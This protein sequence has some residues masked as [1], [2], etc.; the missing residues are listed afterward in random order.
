MIN[1]NK[2]EIIKN[3]DISLKK[4]IAKKL[5]NNYLS[6]NE[7]NEKI[8]DKALSLDDTLPDIYFEKLKLK[9]NDNNLIQKSYD[10]LDKK[11]LDD[12][13]IEKK[14]NYRDIYFYIINYLEN[15]KLNEPKNAKL[16]F[17]KEGFNESFNSSNSN[18]ES[19]NSKI[20][21]NEENKIL[22]REI[23]IISKVEIKD[24]NLSDS[25]SKLIVDD[26]NKLDIKTLLVQKEIICVKDIKQKFEQI[27]KSLFSFLNYR[28]NYPDF[29][30]EL[31]F[32]NN[33]RYMLEAFQRLI[34]KKFIEKIS[35]IKLIKTFTRKMQNGKISDKF[36]KIYFYYIMNSQYTLNNDIITSLCEYDEND[37]NLLNNNNEFKIENNILYDKH[38]KILI[39]NIDY[40]LI[41]KLI[42]QN[43]LT[44][45]DDLFLIDKP[46]FYSLKGLLNRETTF[47]KEE[48]DKMWEEFLSSSVLNDLLNKL[49]NVEINIFK[50]K[51]LINLF[52]QS[53]Y[54]FPN[55]NDDFVALSHKE[56]MLMYFPP[57]KIF[58]LGINIEK[59]KCILEMIEKSL[60][61]INIQ[62]EWGH[63]SS[64]FLFFNS[65]TKYFNTPDRKIKE[66]RK[67][68]INIKDDIRV[69]EGG[70]TVEYL[71]YGRIINEINTKEAIYILDRNNYQKSLQNFF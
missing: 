15:I 57:R 56:L 46:Y 11:L 26:K 33:I 10:L 50:E 67:N 23:E 6:S 66:F 17:E 38:N 1:D 3:Y 14:M 8:L 58:C 49:Y 55:L 32:Y 59:I 31:F 7:K 41:K 9:K 27:Y 69:K 48:G 61:T 25:E 39:R 4:Q 54:Y 18:D 52:K 65:E 21:E 19:N 36:I 34:Y 16:D 42:S 20:S 68:N 24:E 63:T 47:T 71:L 30:S 64:S 62:H 12:L 5:V 60:N 28:N 51:E 70:Y 43:I 53:S 44:E 2:D 29:E 40:Y 13:K 45:R 35:T 37:I 22:F